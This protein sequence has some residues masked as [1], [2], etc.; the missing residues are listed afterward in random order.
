[1]AKLFKSDIRYFIFGITALLC[2]SPFGSGLALVSA[3]VIIGLPITLLIAGFPTVYLVFLISRIIKSVSQF[4]GRKLRTAYRIMIALIV[5]VLP[6]IYINSQYDEQHAAYLNN[7]IDQIEKPLQLDSLAVIFAKGYNSGPICEGS[8]QR[9]LLNGVVK[10]MIMF[11][12]KE[13]HGNLDFSS[14]TGK[15]YWMEKRDTCPPPALIRHNPAG[16]YSNNK[17]DIKFDNRTSDDLIRFRSSQGICLISRDVKLNEADGVIIDGSFKRAKRKVDV[18][19]NI[20]AD[21]ARVHRRSFYLKSNNIYKLAYQKTAVTSYPLAQ[22]LFPTIIPGYGFEVKSGFMRT[23]KYWGDTQ[24]Y[25]RKEKYSEF[26]QDRLGFDLVLDGSE[27][28][29]ELLSKI[30]RLAQT[31][32]ELDAVE[33]S[34]IKDFFQDRGWRDEISEQE[35]DLALKILQNPFIEVPAHTQ[36]IINGVTKSFPERG[37]EFS[38]TLF[39][40]LKS[41]RPKQN[42]KYIPNKYKEL[43]AI[44]NGIYAL[45]EGTINEY[46]P[47]L[48]Q[49]S[50]DPVARIF[51]YSALKRLKESGV[52]GFEALLFLI[53]DAHQYRGFK[54]GI[55]NQWQHPY[56]AGMI[57]LC[58]AGIEANSVLPELL[59]LMHRERLATNGSYGGLLVNTLVRMGADPEQIWPIYSAKNANR[60]RKNFDHEVRRAKSDRPDC[61]F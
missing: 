59:N 5:L 49:L 35:V 28:D 43:K 23:T 60:T 7:D 8:C 37:K 21:T 18:G 40:R 13:P 55:D 3:I 57:G 56:L 34:V 29:I 17:K 41:F 36:K 1:M 12:S 53:E 14:M 16:G 32:I 20:F 2:L 42:I 30:T 33:N 39:D 31:K 15:A 44:S 50:K 11:R 4:V 26:L 48:I 51:G 46:S 52:E 19:F 25:G 45:P 61:S 54:K 27:F 6:P 9:A 38:A 24:R 58:L 10:K 47:Y 22:I